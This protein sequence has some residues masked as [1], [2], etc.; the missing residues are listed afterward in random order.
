MAT[1]LI[2]LDGSVL[3]EKALP[4]ARLLAT[5]LDADI[6]L[7]RALTNHEQARLLAEETVDL[8]DDT[9]PPRAEMNQQIWQMLREEAEAYLATQAQRFR[10]E[11]LQVETRV[12]VGEPASA[13]V[14]QI[15]AIKPTLVVMA[16][17]GYSGMQRWTLGSVTDRVVSASCAP[18][19]IVRSTTPAT[20][21]TIRRILMPLD[22]SKLGAQA[23]P[24]ARML[25]Q[26]AHAELLLLRV[27][28]VPMLVD[29]YMATQY[30]ALSELNRAEALRQLDETAAQL[31]D[32]GVNVASQVA[33]GN[34]AEAIVA[35]AES[36][37]A[38]MIVMAT[39]GYTGLR[40]WA[41]GSVA[42]K[43]L[44]AS[45]TPL[46]LVRSKEAER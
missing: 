13:L 11:G 8:W 26:Q 10:A 39:H 17:H 43:V 28:D 20:P 30:M 44:H 25:A 12:L 6:M 38:D 5:A 1:I 4:H 7:L 31:R 23:L 16:S 2:P 45:T 9:L 46:I 24:L 33:S 42:N 34:V 19:M 37:G 36:Q 27:V 35:A 22:G 29:A 14:E 15:E 18:V 32:E 40:R 41:L 3:A 21:P